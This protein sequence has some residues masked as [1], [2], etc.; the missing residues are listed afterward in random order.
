MF[1]HFAFS[2]FVHSQKRC[3]T[4]ILLAFLSKREEKI[5][6]IK[7]SDRV[8]MVVELRVQYCLE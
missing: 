1:P 2:L 4:K 5:R 6:T 8:D 3:F 7:G